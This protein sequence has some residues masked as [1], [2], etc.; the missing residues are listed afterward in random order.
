MRSPRRLTAAAVLLATAFAGTPALMSSA[1][2]APDADDRAGDRAVARAADR[3]GV[4]ERALRSRL[5]KDPALRLTAG[6]VAYLIDPAPTD[7]DPEPAR[8]VAQQFPLPDTFLLHSKPDSQRTIYLDFNGGDVSNTLWNGPPGNNL[9]NGTHPAMDLAG[10][11]AAFSDTELMQVQDVYQRV[12]EDYAPFDVD[13]TTE[14]PTGRDLDRTGAG[15]HVYGTRALISPSNSALNTICGGGCGGVAFIG[16]FDHYSGRTGSPRRTTS[17]SLPGSSRRRWATTRR[18]SPR[19]PL[20][21][22]G[23]TSAWTTTPPRCRATTPD[24]TCGRRSWASA[25][26]GR[27]RSSR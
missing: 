25:T 8:I 19:R 10:N 14:E 7:A 2:A 23:T 18:T 4:S 15:D 5:S 17:S 22:S 3:Y 12:A 20:T 24:T 27:S 1:N 16:V 9:P 26:T 21:R 11:G 6:G 13:V